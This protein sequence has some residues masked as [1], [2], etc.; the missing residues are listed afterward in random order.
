MIESNNM[1]VEPFNL[2][3]SKDT[4]MIRRIDAALSEETTLQQGLEWGVEHGWLSLKEAEECLRAYHDTV[5]NA[6]PLTEY[7][8]IQTELL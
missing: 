8:D 2:R 1:H 7:I 6:L 3:K 4:E 5:I